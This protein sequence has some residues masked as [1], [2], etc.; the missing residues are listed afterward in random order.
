MSWK[1]EN[2]IKHVFLLSYNKNGDNKK[3]QSSGD[4]RPNRTLN[5]DVFVFIF[6]TCLKNDLI[7]GPLTF[8]TFPDFLPDTLRRPAA[9]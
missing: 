6:Y 8:Q 1:P 5:F 4:K 3:R 9:S 2:R 7:T